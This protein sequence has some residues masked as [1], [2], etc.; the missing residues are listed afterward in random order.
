MYKFGAAAPGRLFVFHYSRLSTAVCTVSATS[1]RHTKRG[2]N[3]RVWE[4]DGEKA[5][6]PFLF[7]WTHKR[8]AP[9]IWSPDFYFVLCG[10]THE[11][12]AVGVAERCAEIEK[13]GEETNKQKK[14]EGFTE[15]HGMSVMCSSAKQLWIIIFVQ[16]DRGN[17]QDSE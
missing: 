5:W 4:Y 17:F 9:L 2:V 6:Q 10:C 12:R 7:N 11:I 16:R 1:P 13:W 3:R 14:K 8:A 15:L